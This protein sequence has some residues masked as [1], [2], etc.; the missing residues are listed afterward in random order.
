M[1]VPARHS[2]GIPRLDEHL[3][4]GLLPGTLTVVVGA[5]GI[6]KTQLGLAYAH[7]GLGQEQRPGVIFDLSYRGDAQFHAEYAQRMF[8]WRLENY[9]GRPADDA[10]FFDAAWQPG[11]YLHVFDS[12]GQRLNPW[13]LEFDAY[14]DRKQQIVEKLQA[15]IAFFYAHFSRQVRRAVI[16][17]VDPAERPSESLQF[18]LFDYIYHQILRKESDWVARDLLR[19][20]F[21]RQAELVE[22]HRYEQNQISGMLLYTS[23]ETLLEPLIERPLVEGDWLANA[24]TV[25]YLGKIRNGTKLTRALYVPK[26]RGSYVSDEIVPYEI[27]PA[28]LQL[29]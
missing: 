8:D 25:I 18:E 12:R 20:N 23:H 21:R 9:V 17:G 3:G 7:A 13:D 1:S 15:T 4:G 16:D 24:N 6:G 28:G 10:R 27:V 11:E 26:H 5:T 14:R 22:Q 29:L 19:Q 2:T